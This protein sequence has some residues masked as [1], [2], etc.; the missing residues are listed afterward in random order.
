MLKVLLTGLQSAHGG[1][2]NKKKQAL[3]AAISGESAATRLAHLESTVSAILWIKVNCL[4]QRVPWRASMKNMHG[5]IN[6][7][8]DYV[9]PLSGVFGNIVNFGLQV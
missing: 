3:V 5:C 9:A 6:Q 4:R 2:P 1:K 8:L 7:R